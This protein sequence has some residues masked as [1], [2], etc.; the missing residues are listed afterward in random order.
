MNDPSWRDGLRSLQP[1]EWDSFV[2]M[3]DSVFRP[4]IVERF[5]H[6]YNRENARNLLVVVASGEVVAQIGTIRRDASILGCRVRVASLGGVG[7]YEAHRGKGYATSLFD[8]TVRRCRAEGVDYILVSGYR[9]IYHRYGCRYVGA[10][11]AYRAMAE[12]ADDFIEEGLELVEVS[13]AELPDMAAVYRRE[14]VRWMRLQEDFDSALQGY[15]MNRPSHFLKIEEKG[16]VRGYLMVQKVDDQNEGRV[17]IQEFAG[18][19][20]SVVGALGKL[21]RDYDL[22]A[23]GIHVMGYDT[24]LQDLLSEK[25]LTGKPANVSGTVCL[26]HFEQLMERMRPYFAERIGE[27]AAKGLVFREDGDEHHFIFGGDRLIAEDRGRAAQVIFGTLDG[28]EDELLSQSGK[29]GEVLR[30]IFPLP[31]L[32]YGPNYT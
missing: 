19:R 22:K 8:E 32:W 7:T 31:G 2:A 12:Q 6:I 9:K 4:G 13:E 17:S 21:I 20:R 30:E 26:V 18:D 29:A 25:G 27:V 16:H 5:P 14:P 11:L 10:D 1:D 24:L 23:V 28:A 3:M 15:V